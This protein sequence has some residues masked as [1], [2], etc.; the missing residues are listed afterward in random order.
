M[1]RLFPLMVIALVLAVTSASRP[2]VAV[3]QDKPEDRKA[4]TGSDKLTQD[5]RIHHFLSRFTLG[6]TPALMAEVKEMGM[7]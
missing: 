3:A 6:A 7:K 2:P 1:C 4:E 5:Q